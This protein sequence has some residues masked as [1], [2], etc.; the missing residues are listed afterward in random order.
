MELITRDI[1]SPDIKF[2]EK[3][4]TVKTK[5]DF[6]NG[7]TFWKTILYEGYGLRPGN[8]VVM[9]DSTIKFNY[10]CCLL[11][12]AAELGLKIILAPEHNKITGGKNDKMDAIVEKFG[13][14]DLCLVDTISYRIPIVVKEIALYCKAHVNVNIFNTYKIKDPTNY[15]L[16]QTTMF[17]NPND[18]VLIATTSGTTGDPKV[19]SYTH[20][21]MYRLARRN[22][23]VYGYANERICHTRNMHHAFI[24]MCHF[25]PVFYGTDQH[26]SYAVPNF[27]ERPS[28]LEPFIN[29][30]ITNKISKLVLSYRMLVDTILNYMIDNQLKFEHDI[31]F[32]TGGFYLTKEYVDKIQK[33]NVKGIYSTFGSNETVSPVLLRYISQDTDT[34]S[35]QNNYLGKPCDDFYQLTLTGQT[36]KVSCPALF[37]DEVITMADDLTGDLESGYY[38]LG[39]SNFYRINEVEFKIFEVTDAIN[40]IFNGK[41]DVIVDLEY[42]KLYMAVWEG[43]ADIEFI[44]TALLNSVRVPISDLANLDEKEYNTQFKLNTSDMREFFR[45]RNQTK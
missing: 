23:Q 11:F 3:D 26:Y 28:D 4:S 43:S 19:L 41:Y 45:T 6:D 7:I 33:A 30:I 37:G 25:L 18:I 34:D 22:S 31:E 12:A 29:F 15:E 20:Q 39:R 14:I 13:L 1:L 9:F 36:L 35:Y 17:A 8:T 10:Y 21:Q 42:Q 38:H 16:M 2:Y 44:N 32:I 5:E 24:F 27:E 40:K